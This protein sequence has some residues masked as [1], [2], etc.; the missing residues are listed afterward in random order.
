MTRRQVLVLAVT[1]MLAGLAEAGLLTVIAAL[2]TAVSAGRSTVETSLG[3]V[4][5]EADVSWV[6]AVGFGLAL[7]RAALQ[8]VNAYLPSSMSATAMATLRERLFDGFV[9]TSWPVQASQ[10]NGHF[11]ALVTGH[12][13]SAA[14]AVIILAQ[15]LS[16]FFLFTTMLVSALVL[17]WVTAALIAALSVTLFLML[18]PLSRQTR[19]YS[20]QFGEQS[21]EYS[22][23]IEEVVQLAEERQVF[24]ASEQYREKVHALIQTV[25]RPLHRL[26][27]ISNL[28]P[29]VHQSVAFVILLVALVV[30]AQLQLHLADLPGGRH[31]HPA[32]VAVVRAAAA[33]LPD[34]GYEL[35]PFLDT[36][37]EAIEHYRANPVQ[38]GDRPMPALRTI[39]TREASFSYVPGRPTLDDFSFDVSC[40]EAVGI[41]GPSGA[42]K[43]TLVQLLLRLRDPDEGVLHV[44]GQDA[45]TIRRADWHREVAYVPQSPSSSTARSRRTSPST[46]RT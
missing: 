37:R 12:V 26:R 28:V 27:F 41:V 11:H 42:G 2:A 32:A 30:V 34:Q 5:V 31:P 44:N 9:D 20:A 7:L 1:S 18:R 16:A 13:T 19:R 36:L 6:F 23:G 3:P 15:G 21:V 35:A 24:G 8:T 45:R 10:R 4:P 33:E 39:G 22:K 38:D 14:G 46:A 17:D 29:V 25:R 43:S 40:G